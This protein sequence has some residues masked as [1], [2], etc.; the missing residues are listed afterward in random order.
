MT[1]VDRAD[2]EEWRYQES[3]PDERNQLEHVFRLLETY[4]GIPHDEI[5]EHVRVLVGATHSCNPARVML[6]AA[7]M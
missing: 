7:D 5:E 1:E 4:S 2:Y 6:D 3:L